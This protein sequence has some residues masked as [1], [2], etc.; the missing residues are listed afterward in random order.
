M[1]QT[2]GGR[3]TRT[4]RVCLSFHSARDKST[5]R[6]NSF[7]S[8][9]VGGKSRSSRRSLEKKKKNME[10]IWSVGCHLG[11]RKS[12]KNSSP[13]AAVANF[14]HLSLLRA[15][16][17]YSLC[18]SFVHRTANERTCA[19]NNLGSANLNFFPLSP[20]IQ[21]YDERFALN[22]TNRAKRTI[23]FPPTRLSREQK[24]EKKFSLSDRNFSLDQKSLEALKLLC[25]SKKK[26]K[27]SKFSLRLNC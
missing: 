26:E 24:P 4:G 21:T 2:G 15:M 3:K 5:Q 13:A 17:L 11:E 12:K 20:P 9:A 7:H 1:K 10:K 6:N 8:I 23:A 18:I 16:Y 19:S 22:E 27:E 25:L 14:P